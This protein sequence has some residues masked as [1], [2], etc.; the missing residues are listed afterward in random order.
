V[1]LAPSERMNDRR[2]ID[3]T[4]NVLRAPIIATVASSPPSRLVTAE[5]E[6]HH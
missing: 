5:H 6:H 1:V 2:D 4:G 3:V